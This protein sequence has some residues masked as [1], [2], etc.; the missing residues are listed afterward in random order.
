LWGLESIIG[1]WIFP[2]SFFFLIDEAK[3]HSASLF[4]KAFIEVTT[5]PKL[6]KVKK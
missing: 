1:K 2:S 6:K 3:Y 4:L 5:N